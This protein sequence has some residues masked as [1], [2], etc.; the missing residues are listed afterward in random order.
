MNKN[1]NLD[2]YKQV[3][4]STKKLVV[5]AQQKFL[6][7]ANRTNIDLYWE[8]GKLLS[9][10]AKK[11][12]WGKAI[13]A[14]LAADLTEAFDNAK[15]YSEQ[16]L[17]FMRQ[18]YH[19]YRDYPQLL[20]VARDVRW[21]T[22]LSIM[23]KVKDTNARRFYLEV[24]RDTLCSRD[25][26][27]SQIKSQTYEREH[28]ADKTHNF[29][30]TLPIGFAEKAEN[31]LKPGYLL[32]VTEPFSGSSK[33]L[34][35]HIEGYMVKHIRKTIMMLGKGFSFIGS[36]YPIQAEGN[37]YFIDLLFFNRV[38]QS[39]VCVELKS[40]KFKAE[41]SGKMNLYLGLLDDYVKQPHENPS[42]GLI[43]CTDRND[44]EAGY[45]LRDV[46]KPMGIAE[47]TL[48]KV[49]PKNL[50]E[51]LPDPKQLEDELLHRLDESDKSK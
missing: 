50:A 13:L 11:H 46:N 49:L 14:R 4:L 24:A 48:A 51:S 43:L 41:Y 25:A 28:L 31:I 36:Q 39:L 1:I 32:E 12:Q 8:I 22:N 35:K 45:A 18:F 5:S 21:R 26:I 30:E 6:K 27:D 17:R 38:T 3:L 15:G 23:T 34:E 10:T 9:E 20:D 29:K 19:E 40:K 16:S 2:D 37:E 42:I 44:F 33:V 7:E 47:L